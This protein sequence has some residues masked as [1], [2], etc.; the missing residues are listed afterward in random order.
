MTANPYYH[1]PPSDHFDGVRFFNPGL[2]TTDRSVGDILR[3]RLTSHRALWPVHVECSPVRPASHV[4]TLTVTMVGHATVLIQ[5]AGRNILVDPVWAERAS[6]FRFMGPRRVTIPGIDFD[7]L[8]PIDAV[9][10]SHNHYDHLDI[11]TLQRLW[12]RDRP[13]I[14]APLGND[15]VIRRSAPSISVD[16]GDWGDVLDVGGGFMVR[17]HPANHWSARTISDRRMALWCG[18]VVE[19]P[20]NTIYVAGDS[21][22]GDGRIFRALRERYASIDLAILPIGAYDPRWFMKDQHADPEEAVQMMLDC[23]AHRAVGVHWGTFPL[24]DEPRREP[25]DRLIAD[26]ARRGLSAESFVALEPGDVCR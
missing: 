14:V 23:G 1:G 16:T 8:P 21:A 19:T 4:D 7:R 12:D 20:A 26:L 10:V 17:I 22:Y 2:P 24:T 18:F 25:K 5:V 9:L 11:S 6:P 15:A 13:R 3:W